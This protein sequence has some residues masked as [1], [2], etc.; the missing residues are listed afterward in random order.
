M[1]IR[2]LFRSSVV[3]LALITGTPAKS[4]DL[5]L[6]EMDSKAFVSANYDTILADD[7]LLVRAM[8]LL[9]LDGHYDNALALVEDAERIRSL[10]RRARYETALI[11]VAS[12]KCD[13]AK[14]Y[15]QELSPVGR[16]DWIADDSRK[17]LRQCQKTTRP[18]W[19]LETA[20][21]YDDNLAASLPL[22]VVRAENGSELAKLIDEVE[23]SVSG[24][25]ID[26]RFT[27][28]SPKVDGW[29]V[30]A[31]ANLDVSIT[32]QKKTYRG[33]ISASR[34][35]TNPQ[36]Y[37]RR[38][39]GLTLDVTHRRAWG[40][41]RTQVNGRHLVVSSG[42][43]LNSHI[44]DLAA[45][46]QSVL[47]PLTKTLDASV[48]IT[49]ITEWYPP[50]YDRKR[51]EQGLRLGVIHYVRPKN[52][53]KAGIL[54][55]W[56][57][58]ATYKRHVAL[59]VYFSSYRHGINGEIR[60]LLPEWE[61]RMSLVIGVEREGLTHSR[62]WRRYPHDIWHHSAKLTFAPKRL[63]KYGLMLELNANASQSKD[64]FD[65]QKT[66]GFAIRYRWDDTNW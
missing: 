49:A 5:L 25:M 8:I 30:D 31:V 43:N 4:S 1:M 50:Q 41:L 48:D 18:R 12:G 13:L 7:Q 2:G 37:N 20:L 52:S 56:Q 55:G 35:L 53:E 36:G 47:F 60:F 10:S 54:S 39:I 45:I 63:A 38:G 51:Q 6:A 34:R 65:R 23:A 64:R 22:R 9:R 28:G 42:Q 17:F 61:N 19:S 57:I 14:P 58:N 66:W 32:Q 11:Y 15:F 59:P 33:E 24:I 27:L 26:D 16:Q 3:M 44:H 40:L 29:F 21:G 62:P 46:E